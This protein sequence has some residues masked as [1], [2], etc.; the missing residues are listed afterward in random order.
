[1]SI[2]IAVPSGIGDIYWIMTK[3]EAFCARNCIT[4]KPTVQILADPGIW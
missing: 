1:M 3:L 2:R 4:E